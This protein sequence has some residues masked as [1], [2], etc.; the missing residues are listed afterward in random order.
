MT[1]PSTASTLS[2]S[3]TQRLPLSRSGIRGLSLPPSPRGAHFPPRQNA[4]GVA[5]DDLPRGKILVIENEAIV[6]LDLQCTLREAGYRV[7]GPAA[8][9]AEVQ[10]LIER[11]S[12][13]CAIVDLD[14]DRRTPLP[15]A[16]LLAFAEVPFVFL[17]TGVHSAP[18][19]R[20]ASRPV[21]E[22]PFRRAELLRAVERAMTRR[23]PRAASDN[24]RSPE[25]SLAAWPRVFPPL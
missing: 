8:K 11:G 23:S 7:V 5:A 20:H 24:P 16:D 4:S 9:M 22:K 25:A 2:D 13:D 21:V 17:T 18:P 14:V 15:V 1:I 6:A 10:R 3:W 12:I 19:Q